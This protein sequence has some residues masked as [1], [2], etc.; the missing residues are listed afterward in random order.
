VSAQAA[1]S[2]PL[3]SGREWKPVY[4]TEDGDLAELFYSN[5][6]SR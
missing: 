1:E 4:E 6:L 3:L 5:S 2:V